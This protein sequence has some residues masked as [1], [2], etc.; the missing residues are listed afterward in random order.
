MAPREGRAA[1]GS[2][3]RVTGICPFGAAPG[4]LGRTPVAT[5]ERRVTTFWILTALLAVLVAALLVLALLRG[6][7]DTRAGEA[8]DRA[9][10]AKAVNFARLNWLDSVDP[11]G[12]RADIE[13]VFT[14]IVAMLRM[15]Q[16]LREVHH[17]YDLYDYLPVADV[18]VD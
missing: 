4:G 17:S 10:T 16:E 6:V 18:N 7:R 9:G 13:Q 3:L 2:R 15:A 11:G 12:P 5:E 8:F 14:E 1:P